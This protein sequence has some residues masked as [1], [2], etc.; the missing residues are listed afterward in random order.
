MRISDWSSDVCSS[1][2]LGQVLEL[3]A[4]ET[5]SGAIRA[6]LDLTPK[7]ARRVRSD[8]S[9]EEVALED[10]AVGDML[11]IRPGEK[12][13]VDGIILEG[14]GTVDES[15]V[16]GESMP[17]TKEAGAALIGGTI[18]QTGGLLMRSEKV[19]RDKIGRAHV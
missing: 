5:T 9:D 8:G 12:V 2:L 14:R 4:R 11:R 1:D 19:G 13:P 3:R 6:L 16:T 7:L 10:V 18:N 15:L 17:V